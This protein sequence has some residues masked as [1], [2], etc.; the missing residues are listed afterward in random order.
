LKSK[1]LITKLDDQPKKLNKML[2]IARSLCNN[3][4]SGFGL[5]ARRKISENNVICPLGGEIC[6]ESRAQT[7]AY[8]IQVAPNILI[9]LAG[10]NAGFPAFVNDPLNPLLENCIIKWDDTRKSYCLVAN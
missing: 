9:D 7:S 10:K 3:G 4:N 6:E 1:H 5:F 8:V 2:G